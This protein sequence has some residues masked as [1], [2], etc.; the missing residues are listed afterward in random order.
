M[1]DVENRCVSRSGKIYVSLYHHLAYSVKS[2]EDRRR[3]KLEQSWRNSSFI[4][5]I[6]IYS[7]SFVFS[8]P[9]CRQ[10]FLFDWTL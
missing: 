2:V 1:E 6:R 10:L 4:M 8:K 5:Q 3:E 7:V 9:R